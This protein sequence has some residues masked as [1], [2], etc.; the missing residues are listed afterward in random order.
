MSLNLLKEM[1]QS[2]VDYA[3]SVNTDRSIPDAATGLKPVHRRILYSCY[4]NKYFSN[5]KYVKCARITGNVIGTLHP[6]GDVSVYDALVRLAQP[7][8]MRYPLIDFHGNMG[9]IT[10]DGPASQRYTEARL[11][12]LS[13]F[14][15]LQNVKTTVDFVPN[16]D[17]TEMEPIQ[18]PAIFPNLLCNPTAGIGVAMATGFAPHNLREITELIKQRRNGGWTANLAPDFPTGGI[19][20]NRDELP[21]FYETGRGSIKIRGKYHLE[22]D[23]IVF[24]EIPYGVTLESLIDEIGKVAAENEVEGISDVH[25]ETGDE[26]I[27]VV[28]TPMAGIN[29]NTIIPKLFEKTRLQNYFVLNMRAL[30]N[31]VP[32]LFSMKEAVDSYLEFN[33]NC[34]LKESQAEKQKVEDRLEVLEGLIKAIDIIDEIITLI[35]TSSS[36]VEAKQKL[37]TGFHFSERQAQAILDLKLARLAKLENQKLIDEQNELTKKLQWLNSLIESKNNRLDELIKRLDNLTKKY[38]DARRTEVQQIDLPTTK[39]EKM[40]SAI[41][42]Q[43]V[44]V[45]I[46][47]NNEIKR[48][49]A[50]KYVP[51]HRNTKG[52]RTG[53]EVT[54][55]IIKTNTT[56]Y[57]LLF[58]NKGKMYRLL[59]DKIPESE[60]NTRGTD[61]TSL[62]NLAD[63]E[64]IQAATHSYHS[65]NEYV[66]FVTKNG[67]VK[68]TL[69]SEYTSSK[70]NCG[71]Q[72]IKFKDTTDA[73]TQINFVTD[74]NLI[75]ITHNG[76]VIRFNSSAINPIGRGA[77]GVRGIALAEDDYVVTGFAIKPQLNYLA[78]ISE[79]G[80]GKR[81]ELSE[82]VIQNRG[83]KGSSCYKESVAAAA[84]V[85]DNDIVFISGVGNAVCIN[86]N[87]IPIQSRGATGNQL[88]K[89]SKVISMGVL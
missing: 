84:L 8:I 13:E 35:K 32:K 25:D 76:M 14:G 63:G 42:P 18:L 83:G 87:E 36:T 15:M 47:A 20:I 53:K 1:G 44:V 2:F 17:E 61:L 86:A 5:K 72:A 79:N 89:T 55:S 4:Q 29:P 3:M 12:P 60:V 82:F 16:Y 77:I 73:L 7:W 23:K 59:V 46:L 28:I 78:I 80:K 71:I 85:K 21:Q 48:I 65:D 6:H 45:H 43:E 40:K 11:T 64:I 19:I 50:E 52:V 70:R 81:I 37:Q 34:I 68:K 39:A 24:T 49:P 26:G 74:E 27:R 54:L 58:S 33:Q 56:D 41:I 51:Q 88:I 31:G 22:K 9:A 30:N 57:L 66:I 62:L 75:L 67:F 69:L 10:G 38:G